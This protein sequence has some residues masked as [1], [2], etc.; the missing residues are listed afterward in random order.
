[1]PCIYVCI[2]P[3]NSRTIRDIETE[4]FVTCYLLYVICT[5]LGLSLLAFAQKYLEIELFYFFNNIFFLPRFFNQGIKITTLRK[6]IYFLAQQF[7]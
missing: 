7:R 3:R 2:L 6:D 4:L 5:V 1:M